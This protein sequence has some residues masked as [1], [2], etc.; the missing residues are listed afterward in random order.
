[1]Y[2]WGSASDENLDLAVQTITGLDS[3]PS[4]VPSGT[5]G[6]AA[7]GA[8]PVWLVAAFLLGLAGLV[9][10]VGT[11]AVARVRARP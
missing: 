8:M 7:A 6:Q 4:G 3:A 2:A 10:S 5:G 1:M 9:A 11:L